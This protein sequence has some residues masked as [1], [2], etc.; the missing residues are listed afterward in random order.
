MNEK[1]YVFFVIILWIAFG[2]TLYLILETIDSPSNKIEEVDS[3][4]AWRM[5]NDHPIT[6]CPFCGVDVVCVHGT[7]IRKELSLNE[8]IL[9]VAIPVLA[10]ITA[11]Y[12]KRKFI[13]RR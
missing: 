4:T 9:I 12:I 2:I 11:F 3:Y 5:D 1:T 6:K 8:T 13:K 10:V 7:G